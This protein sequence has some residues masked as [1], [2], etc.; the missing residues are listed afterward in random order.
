MVL[1]V[2]DNTPPGGPFRRWF[3]YV[4]PSARC[5]REQDDRMPWEAFGSG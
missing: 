3:E 5:E 4:A 2:A 1:G